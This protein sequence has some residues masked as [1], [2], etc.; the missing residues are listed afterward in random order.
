M[1]WQILSSQTP[2]NQQE[3]E[4]VLLSNRK[5]TDAE[6]FFHPTSPFKISVEEVGIDALQMQKAV[7]RIYEAKEKKQDV[8]IFGDYDADGICATATL[9]EAL[10]SVGVLARPFIPHREKHGYG[11]SLRSLAAVLE[12]KKPDLLITVDNGI[13]ANDAFAEL[14]RLGV[15]TILTDHHQPD[16]TLPP[17][18]IILHTTKV[19]GTGVAWFFSRSLNE[20]AAQRSLDLAAIATIADQMPLLEINRMIVT[21]GLEALRRTE[22]V[23]LQLLITKANI[24]TEKLDA[25]SVNY[26]IAPRINAMGRIKHGMDALRLLCTKNMERA[27]QLVGELHDTN[28]S[29]QEMTSSMIEEAL[30]HSQKWESEHLIIVA[31]TEYHEGVIGLLAG[32][33]TETFYKPAIAIAL[34]DKLAKASARSVRG[35]NI[36]DLIRLVKEDLLE[37]GGH[38]MAA[39]FGFLPEKLEVVKEKLLLIAKE[40]INVELLHPSIEVDCLLP[41]KMANLDMCE[42]IQRFAPFGQ[43]NREPIFGFQNV[44]IVGAETMGKDGRHLKFGIVPAEFEASQNVRP[45]TCIAWKM[46][47]K[48]ADFA[49][50]SVVNIAASLSCNEWKNRKSLQMM[51][52]DIQF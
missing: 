26:A 43:R 38:P 48:A 7:E 16:T 1:Q 28:V 2:Q 4:S 8:L 23:G 17:A 34:G 9:W 32:K 40:Q 46:G 25:S 10:K 24:D 44:K 30:T 39:G 51:V 47:D 20:A 52:R 3:L 18:D 41:F 50:G 27:D 12:E 14:Q 37:A 15:S 11:L 42:E 49:N 22:R 21:H 29:R 5:I 33:L 31:S 6:A 13:V 36:I 45:I 19:S 35:V